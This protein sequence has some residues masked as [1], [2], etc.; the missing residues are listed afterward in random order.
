MGVRST[1]NLRY[2]T[3]F[4]V[5]TTRQLSGVGVS[6]LLLANCAGGKATTGSGNQRIE[7]RSVAAADSAYNLVWLSTTIKN[8]GSKPVWLLNHVDSVFANCGKHGSLELVG[9]TPAGRDLVFC[10]YCPPGRAKPMIR[11]QQLAAGAQITTALQVDFNRVFPR[12]S[13]VSMDSVCARFVNRT[14]GSYFFRVVATIYDKAHRQ[15]LTDS[16]Q[17]VSVYRKE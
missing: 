17:V 16:S 8:V 2:S 3:Y 15:L 7:I 12:S 11:Y 10:K 6:L 14:T 4:P 13:N 9:R 5:M 1:A